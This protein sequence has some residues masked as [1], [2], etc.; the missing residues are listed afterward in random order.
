MSRLD[1]GE[2]EENFRNDIRPVTTCG[3]RS[4]EVLVLARN[5][6]TRRRFVDPRA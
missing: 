6:G 5:A 4:M 2:L 1:L 3:D